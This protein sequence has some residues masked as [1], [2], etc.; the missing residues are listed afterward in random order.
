MAE[1]RNCEKCG[2]ELG[3]EASFC[4]SCGAHVGSAFTNPKIGMNIR[5]VGFWVI[6][7]LLAWFP[8]LPLVGILMHNLGLSPWFTN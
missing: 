3:A 1:A 5:K 7:G 4:T 8:T 2:A 6:V